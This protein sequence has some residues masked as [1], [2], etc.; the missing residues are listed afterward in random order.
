MRDVSGRA[1]LM[2]K[3]KRIETNCIFRI[4]EFGVPFV[5]SGLRTQHSVHEDAVLTTSLAQ[6]NPVLPQAAA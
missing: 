6:W 5:L 2:S 4:G 3:E 1:T